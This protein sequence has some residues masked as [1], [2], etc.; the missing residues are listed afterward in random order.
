V[1]ASN[2]NNNLGWVEATGIES[3]L[4]EVVTTDA[5]LEPVWQK[6]SRSE[7]LTHLRS[8]DALLKMAVARAR[9]LYAESENEGAFQGLYISEQEIDSLLDR[10]R[11]ESFGFDETVAEA[12]HK[13][14]S[15]TRIAALDERWAFT[16]FDNAVLVLALAPELDLRY[17]RIYA[18]LQDDVTRRRPS[19]DLALNL[20]CDSPEARVEQRSRFAPDAPLLRSGLLRLLSDS[21]Q[22][23]PP[24]LAQYLRLDERA[25]RTLLGDDG[26][27]SR[28]VSFCEREHFPARRLDLGDQNDIVRRLPAF[29]ATAENGGRPVRLL[30]SGPA[31][32]SK[33]QAVEA[34]AAANQMPL[35]AADM[36]RY[37]AWRTEP[38]EI[39]SL[40]VREATLYDPI[41]FV[42]GLE[43]AA[44]EEAA[45]KS[46]IEILVNYPGIVVLASESPL[47]AAIAGSDK[48]LNIPFTLPDY[49]T[50]RALWQ[51]LTAEA[52]IEASPDW[53]AKLSNNFQLAPEQIA[54]AVHTARQRLEW[55][56]TASGK[57]ETKD[58]G[59][60]LLAAA[61]GQTGVELAALTSKLKPVYRWTDIVLPEDTR[62][63]LK[64]IC[65]RVTYSHEVMERGG[66]GKK[67]SAGKG[68]AVL[69]AGSSGTGKTM[70]AEVIANELGLDL[71]RIDLSSVVS[72]YI[73]ETE[74]NL[75]R[76]FTAA[77]R[78]NSVLL[79]DEADSLF[80]KRSSVNDAHDRYANIE[81]SYL[82]QKMEQYEGL[83]ILTSNLRGNIDEAFWRRLAFTVHFPF[84][85]EATRLE[86]WKGIW[87]PET[88]VSEDVDF[89]ALARRFRLSGGNIRNI[90]LAAAFQ[91]AAQSRPVN[92]A[93]I[94]HAT[95]REY[96]KVGKNLTA[97][98]LEGEI[99]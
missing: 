59:T 84:P 61:R 49:D 19:V 4:D 94:L 52:G 12:L 80:G 47:V 90:G 15:S 20:F 67:L 27:D 74:K 65:R 69:F 54:A 21:S 56:I 26:L 87:P 10:E 30:F 68:V 25:I 44:A 83:T 50:R 57:L 9:V 35:L 64:E 63:Q 17:E 99:Q 53:L 38:V 97:A 43:P 14:R 39:A 5:A 32:S 71:F 6:D 29:A 66:F 79:F 95:R 28:L 96:A 93:D 88:K 58:T 60:E 62:E 76:I 11:G 48:F 22:V 98:E 72:K 86:I 41:L 3:A 46:L 85:E 92:M 37:A 31:T 55:Q 82:L 91:A 45:A 78:S 73:G 77:A 24:L 70:A 13:F 18:Y 36:Q 51:R 1:G 7:I 42:G 89:A 75:E 23:E 8:L 40:L 33:R 34:L 2:I 81:V 16:D